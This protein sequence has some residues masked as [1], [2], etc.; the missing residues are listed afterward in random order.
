MKL[1][2]TKNKFIIHMLKI[3]MNPTLIF[4]Y[5]RYEAYFIKVFYKFKKSRANIHKLIQHRGVSRWLDRRRRLKIFKF[6]SLVGGGGSDPRALRRRRL[7]ILKFFSPVG[8]G[9]GGWKIQK[10]RI[11]SKI[12][13]YLFIS[14][15]ECWSVQ[16]L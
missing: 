15:S 5:H 4:F 12:K 6:F 13:K 16:K 8:G 2:H 3:Q 14:I 1:K 11:L 10:W 7:E 9:G